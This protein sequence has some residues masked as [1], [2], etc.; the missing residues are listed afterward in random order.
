M[1]VTINV[2]KSGIMHLRKKMV[3]RCE[4]EY[5]VDGKVIPMVSSYKYLG[6]VVDEHLEFKEM[7]EE[8]ATAGRRVLGAWLNRC[9]VEVGNVEIGAFKK[10]MSALVNSAM[11]RIWG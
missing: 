10:L 4:V 11:L 6:C 2:G 1:G 9:R 8:K 3:E 7:V 5:E